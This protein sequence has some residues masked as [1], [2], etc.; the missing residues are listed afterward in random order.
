VYAPT[1]DRT[2]EQPIAGAIAVKPATRVVLTEGNY[3]LDRSEPWDTVRD[4]L[5]HVWF[6]DLPDDVRREQLI[7][8]HVRFGKAPKDARQWVNEVDEPNAV[9]IA[10]TRSL[11]DVVIRV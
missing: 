9:R 7:A 1:F 6:C 8:R 2:I 10:A 4:T 3:L 5:T 11:A